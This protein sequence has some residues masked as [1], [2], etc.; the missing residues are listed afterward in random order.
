MIVRSDVVL[1]QVSVLDS[2][3]AHREARNSEALVAF[4]LHNGSK[5]TSV[6]DRDSP[7]YADGIVP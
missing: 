3:M 2:I 1:P 6:G 7:G 5:R 4:F